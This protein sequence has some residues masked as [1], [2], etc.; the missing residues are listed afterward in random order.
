[1]FLKY[2][3]SAIGLH[4]YDTLTQHRH[5]LSSCRHNGPSCK[6][7]EL[8]RTGASSLA[9]ETQNLRQ[10]VAVFKVNQD[11]TDKWANQPPALTG[12]A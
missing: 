4:I 11:Q 7:E 9:Q 5:V 8:H 6:Q 2:Q 1:V 10:A 12:Y 3:S